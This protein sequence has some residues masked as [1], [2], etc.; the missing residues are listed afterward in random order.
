M[1]RNTASAGTVAGTG[2]IRKPSGER[3]ATYSR[4][5][6]KSPFRLNVGWNSP[7]D[8]RSAPLA[9]HLQLGRWCRRE[10]TRDRSARMRRADPL[11]LLGYE[12][13]TRDPETLW[14]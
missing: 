14:P 2:L 10:N 6:R 11:I 9:S 13:V 1:V 12:L 3:G 8:N 7:R 5:K 4:D